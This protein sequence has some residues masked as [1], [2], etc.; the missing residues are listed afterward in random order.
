M[1]IKINVILREN[2][3]KEGGRTVISYLNFL[4]RTL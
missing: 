2:C 4:Q 1:N 3:K